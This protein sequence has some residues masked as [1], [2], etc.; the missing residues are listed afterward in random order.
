MTVRQH[1]DVRLAGAVRAVWEQPAPDLRRLLADLW[2]RWVLI[3]T[4]SA[5]AFFALTALIL[6]RTPVWYA[7]TKIAI[8]ARQPQ[9]IA[10]EQTLAIFA[11]GALETEVQVLR[12]HELIQEV[13]LDFGLQAD[14][15]F[16]PALRPPGILQAI[17]KR[18][19]DA[20]ERWMPQHWETGEHSLESSFLALAIE[21]FLANLQIETVG[22]SHVIAV[23]L[24]STDRVRVADAVNALID[25]YLA[26]QAAARRELMSRVSA[27]LETYVAKLEGRMR[28][29][30][31]ALE[32]F[33]A[34]RGL[35]QA[36]DMSVLSQ[37]LVDLT[38][39]LARAIADR[40]VAEGRL[41]QVQTSVWSELAI[42][43]VL[44][45]GHIQSMLADEAALAAQ[46]AEYAT[47]YGD[48]HP[49]M[50]ELRRKLQGLQTRIALE[51]RRIESSFR[52][53]VVAARMREQTIRDA[54]RQQE[55]VLAER[56]PDE[57]TLRQLERTAAAD[58]NLLE[59]LQSRARELGA[60]ALFSRPD[61]RVVTRAQMPREPAGP[62]KGTLL[63]FAFPVSLAMGAAA[64]LVA[65]I[66]DRTP[67]HFDQLEAAIGVPVTSAI[68]WIPM[69]RFALVH[70]AL[71]GPKPDSTAAYLASTALMLGAMRDL[72]AALVLQ[73][74]EQNPV[75]LFTSSVPHEG[76]TTTAIAFAQ[77]LVCYG[78]K[79]LFID[80]DLR[81]PAAHRCLG[82]S[83]RPGL[84]DSLL[85]NCRLDQVIQHDSAS[86]IA[87]L[88]V[89]GMYVDVSDL[90]RDRALARLLEW[91]KRN[92]DVTVIDSAPVLSAAET[93]LLARLADCTV[94]L[95]R[96][97]R[98]PIGAALRGMGLLVDSGARVAGITLSMV[99]K[100][101][102][103]YY[104]QLDPDTLI[105]VAR[106]QD[107]PL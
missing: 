57:A 18:L 46:V 95:V 37:R 41:A 6:T 4:T 43:E 24:K 79:V 77:M 12:S 25:H 102:L 27:D 82:L 96:W 90:G 106:G 64:A 94:F 30:E 5:F 9:A 55:T 31:Q 81:Q 11:D 22:R 68:P 103:S 71:G 54:I 74:G 104:H 19:S 34:E 15:D 50:V 63:V 3:A 21:E 48:R 89:G 88:P 17:K 73:A 16:N 70:R 36:R 98:T 7:E 20:A 52:N 93:R 28:G 56:S 58:R 44:Q 14:P 86:G 107:R 10:A 92:Y 97:S 69:Y 76:K 2:R 72:H 39:E 51:M 59:S 23:S 45:S 67:R 80:G 62:S 91:A 85:S 84:S 60:A 101:E 42:P 105:Q 35:T 87:F 83:G 78:R 38:N 49:A 40:A 29:S 100:R 47:L 1:E 99:S 65:S 33:R 75:I 66:L 61:A 32:Q 53:G 26:A 8:D 13:I